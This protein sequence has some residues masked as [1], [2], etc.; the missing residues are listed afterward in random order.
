MDWMKTG[1]GLRLMKDALPPR[2]TYPRKFDILIVDE[3]HNVAPASASHHVMPSLRTRLI[4]RIAPHFQHRLFLTATPH[5]GYQESFTALL[6]LLDDQRFARSVMPDEQQLQRVMVRRL[7]TDLVDAH[8]NPIYP[9]RKIEILPVAYT[10]EEQEAHS[11]LR[12]YTE[13]RKT[14]ADAKS[15][16]AGAHFVHKL[17]KKRLFSSPMAFALTLQ[18]HRKTLA[19]GPK[20]KATAMD[21]RI[22]RKAILKCEEDYADDRAFEAAEDEAVEVATEMGSQLSDEERSLLDQLGTWAES[23]KN[24]ADSK[25][26][27]L[28]EWLDEHLKTDGQPNDKRV[29]LF[30]EYRATLSWLQEILVSRGWGGDKLLTLHGGTDPEDR[31]HIK[32]AFQAD[33]SVSPVRILLATDAA[34]EGIDLQNHCNYLIHVEIPWNPNVMEQRNGRIDRHGQRSKKVHI[35]HPVGAS[36]SGKDHSPG[37]L[38][39]DHE[40]LFR[41]VEKVQSMREDLGCVGPVI[42]QQIEEAMLGERQQMDTRAAEKKASDIKKFVAAERKLEERIARLHQRLLEARTTLRL[43]PQRIQ[44][45][46]D[47]ALDLAGKPAMQ[48]AMLAKGFEGE[49]FDLP[50]L[51]GSWDQALEGLPHP[52]TGA[53]RPI[54]FD[55]AAAQGRDDVVLA[56]LQHKLVQMSLRLLRAEVWAPEDRKNLHR[57]AIRSLPTG[58]SKEPVVVVWSRLVVTGGGHH[59]LHEELTMAAG[60]LKDSGFARIRKIGRIEELLDSS[61]GATPAERTFTLLQR[62]FET[63]KEPILRAVDARSKERLEFLNKTLERRRDAEEKDLNGVLDDLETLIRNELAEKKEPDQLD[64]WPADQLEQLRRDTAALGARLKRI[65]E[66]RE[67]EIASIR[68]RYEAP[69]PHTFPVAVEFLV[70]EEMLRGGA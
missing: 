31:E 25:A 55:H 41:A 50:L 4:R 64:L 46:V 52:H 56:H 62:R 9:T 38:N 6:E 8:G 33:P 48:P 17:L 63:Q 45:A 36:D 26:D 61:Q 20:K 66:E 19:R 30:T 39:G 11:L 12:R 34:S 27:A 14:S 65:P 58:A 49:A 16:R 68:R 15:R 67:A 1:E 21:E 32:A 5:N 22:L 57:V 28:L 3:A 35:W 70:P 42:A 47:V 18:K 53:R 51:T 7:K 60:E 2:V 29:I 37:D 59:R 23:A 54:T 40:F 69:A 43:E 10:D 24:R 13:T 44:R